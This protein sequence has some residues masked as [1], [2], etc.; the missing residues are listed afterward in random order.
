VFLTEEFLQDLAVVQVLRQILHDD[1]LS[2]QHVIDP[3]DQYL[4][5]QNK[6][7]IKNL[8]S[9]KN[10]IHCALPRRQRKQIIHVYAIFKVHV[11]WICVWDGH[12]ETDCNS[13]MGV[14]T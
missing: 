6:T 1:P 9:K 8:H 4:G 11:L 10:W 2:H 14:W 7:N 5:Q 3:V 12:D 13:S